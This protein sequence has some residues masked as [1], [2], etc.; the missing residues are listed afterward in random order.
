MA[1]RLNRTGDEVKALLDSV[2]NKT[3]YPLASNCEAGLMSTEDKIKLDSLN[4]EYNTTAYWDSYT[5]YIP[6]R[7][8]II[9]YSDYKSVQRDGETVYVPG[10]KVGSG[11]GYVQDLGFVDEAVATQLLSHIQN[12][13]IHVT[14]T[15][16][17]FWNNKLNINDN[18]EVV[19]N[20]LIF[21]RD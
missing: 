14:A 13:G 5:G 18:Q 4:I 12:T 1:Y 7:G 11:N 19:G 16:K 6:P 9:V 15:E 3:I 20:V 17:T 10:I 21:N 8:T 2:E